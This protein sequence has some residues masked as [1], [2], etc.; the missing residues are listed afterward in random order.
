MWWKAIDDGGHFRRSSQPVNAEKL[1]PFA[2]LAP[3]PSGPVTN[4]SIQARG[5]GGGGLCLATNG[6]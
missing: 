2:V 6:T 4:C 5:S 1:G 3:Q